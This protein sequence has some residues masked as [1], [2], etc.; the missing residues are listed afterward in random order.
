MYIPNLLAVAALLRLAA[1]SRIQQP[2]GSGS[3]PPTPHG[4][5]AA[6]EAT[7]DAAPSWRNDLISLHRSLIEIPSISG[8]ESEAGKFLVDYLTGRGYISHLQFLPP[9]NKD[10]NET[11][12]F[13]V[14]AWKSNERQPK[15]RIVVTSHYD[16]VPP[17][18][19]YSISDEKITSETRISGRGSVDAKASV[20]AQIIAL[21]DLL[22]EDKVKEED[23]MLLF[24]VGEEDT[25]DGMRF[26][27]DSLQETEPRLEFESVI[28]GE[29][30]ESKLACGHK[31]G[32]FCDITAK[33]IAG[34]SG[35]PWLG[36]SA[37]EIMVKALAKIISTD[38]GSSEKWG[39]TTVNVGQIIGGVAQNVIPEASLARI[40][41]RVAIGPEAD[42]G[43]IVK[44]R[45]QKILDETDAEDLELTCTHGYGVVEANCDVEGFETIVANYGTDI[46][47]LKGSHTRYLYGPGT[48]LVA[49]GRNENLTV[50]ELEGAVTGFQKLILHALK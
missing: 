14:L 6:T 12:R 28:F 42:G 32:V 33:G 3:A 7:S 34:H 35:Y 47:N 2:L 29:P 5:A 1:T 8:N 15:P 18:I 46:P 39:N 16:V 21:E 9:R 48:I 38:L 26:F 4:P 19:P 36:K 17:H 30:T 11:P 13:N 27:S 41:V 23:V 43:N 25:G 45:I 24:V 31:G 10:N 44:G 20:A 50:A 49:H 40:A 37:N 22:S